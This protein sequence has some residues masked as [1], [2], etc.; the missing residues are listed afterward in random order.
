MRQLGLLFLICLTHGFATSAQSPDA[1]ADI[2]HVVVAGETLTF[3]ANTYGLTID[4]IAASNDIDPNAI[5]RVGQSLR[6]SFP[7]VEP[8]SEPLATATPG[9]AQN[10]R[11]NTLE[12]EV[13]KVLTNGRLDALVVMPDTPRQDLPPLDPRFCFAMFSD[14][15]RNA[16]LDPGE[17]ILPGGMIALHDGDEASAYA[18]AESAES[19]CVDGLSRQVYYITVTPPANHS[20]TAASTLR[21]DLRNGMPLELYIGV[22]PGVIQPASIVAAPPTAPPQGDENA[23]QSLLGQISGLLVVG[24]AVTVFIS[25]IGLALLL[26][27]R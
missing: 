20:L 17:Q 11:V 19:Y 1:F 7:V 5:L 24:L 9:S 22:I 18:S 10:D 16:N 12:Q 2:D 23:T 3:I 26:R 6:I 25:G 15:N 8:T 27:L 21:L 14:N 13:P 4:D